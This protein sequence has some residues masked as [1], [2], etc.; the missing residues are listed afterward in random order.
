MVADMIFV[1]FRL[2]D[3]FATAVEIYNFPSFILVNSPLKYPCLVRLALKFATSEEMA[4]F[5]RSKGIPGVLEQI[6]CGKV[7]PCGHT[8]TEGPKCLVLAGY[9]EVMWCIFM[10][11]RDGGDDVTPPMVQVPLRGH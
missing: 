2:S 9:S 7:A 10:R 5:S 11:K 1:A 3:A 6:S 8:S 4:A